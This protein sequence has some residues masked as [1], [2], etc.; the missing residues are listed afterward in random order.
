MSYFSNKQSWNTISGYNAFLSTYYEGDID[1]SGGDLVLRN[2]NVY[3][4]PS[5][6]INT[7]AFYTNIANEMH[8][9]KLP[10]CSVT[11]A[12]ASDLT[13]KS[14]VDSS[15]SSLLSSAISSLLSL[16]NTWTN[17][18][19]F[20]VL[21]SGPTSV[22]PSSPAD[23][24]TKQYADT[25]ISHTGQLTLV[26]TYLQPPSVTTTSALS[27]STSYLSDGSSLQGR[28]AGSILVNSFSTSHMSNAVQGLPFVVNVQCPISAKFIG[29]WEY[30]VVSNLTFTG[31]EVTFTKNGNSWLNYNGFNYIL[32]DNPNF[33]NFLHPI[34]SYCNATASTYL[35][36]GNFYESFENHQYLKNIGITFQTD[37]YDVSSDDVYNV[38]VSLQYTLL[39]TTNVQ[40][41]FE[42]NTNISTQS[43]TDGTKI[44][45]TLPDGVNYLPPKIIY[46]TMVNVSASQTGYFVNAYVDNVINDPKAC[47][48]RQYVDSVALGL[49]FTVLGSGGYHVSGVNGTP[50]LKSDGTALVV[51]NLTTTD[52]SNVLLNYVSYTSFTNTLSTYAKTADIISYSSLSGLI[53]S[54]EQVTTLITNLQI[55]VYNSFVL[56]SFFDVWEN[57]LKDVYL[58]A[59]YVTQANLSNYV[60]TGTIDVSTLTPYS[61]A[62][63][64][65]GHLCTLSNLIA[66]Q[67][68]SINDRFDFWKSNT[69]DDLMLNW[70][71]PYYVKNEV[72]QN[73]TLSSVLSSYALT[74]SLPDLTPYTLSVRLQN[75]T[76]SSVLSSYALTS[77]LPDLT[78]YALITTLSSLISGASIADTINT[79]TNFNHFTNSSEFSNSEH[80]NTNL[81]IL[82]GND[83]TIPI[84]P[85]NDGHIV[86]YDSFINDFR[87]S[88]SYAGDYNWG[89]D[90]YINNQNLGYNYYS[91]VFI[92]LG[93]SYFSGIIK[94]LGDY[95]IKGKLKVRGD[96]EVQ[97]TTTISGYVKTSDLSPYALTSSLPAAPDLTPYV[98]NQVLQNY[99]LSS[100]LSSY[101]LTS[102]L[103]NLAPIYTQLTTLSS[104]IRGASIANTVNTFTN[105]NYFNDRVIFGND[106]TIP[107][108]NPDDSDDITI[109]EYTSF[110]TDLA[111]NRTVGDFRLTAGYSGTFYW[112][113][114][115]SWR[116]ANYKQSSLIVL[117]DSYF[118]GNSYQLG[119][120][121]R[122]GNT[123]LAGRFKIDGRILCNTIEQYL[124]NYNCSFGDAFTFRNQMQPIN[125]SSYLFNNEDQINGYGDGLDSTMNSTFQYRNTSFGLYNCRKLTTGNNNCCIANT[126]LANLTTGNGNVVCGNYSGNFIHSGSYNTI[127]GYCVSGIISDSS[128]STAI[129]ALSQITESH[130]IV[131]G[132]SNEYVL[133]QGN[134]YVQGTISGYVTT[135]DLT[136]YALTSSL[137]DLSPYAMNEVL[138]NYTLSSSLPDLTPYALSVGLQNYT[139]SSSLSSYALTSAL[140]DLTPYALSVRLQNYTLSSSLSSYAL[141]SALPDLT[142]YAL[143]VRLQNY[144]L[145]SVLSSYALT[146][147]LPDLTP[148]AL[149]VRLQ[150]YTLSSV[151]SSYALTSA[152]SSYVDIT[153]NQSIAG[154]KT[155]STGIVNSSSITGVGTIK[156]TNTTTSSSTATGALVV[157]GGA[158]IGGA[159]NVGSG[160]TI[161]S[162]QT[163]HA[164]KFGTASPTAANSPTGQFVSF[165]YT[166]S[167][168]P[169]VTTTLLYKNLIGVGCY[170][171]IYSVST[172]GFYIT[173]AVI[174]SN[175]L[176]E[177]RWNINWIAIN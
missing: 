125:G 94:H 158:G 10:I 81:C 96:L 117:G 119:D 155:F 106:I 165:G 84:A 25:L 65:S 12:N 103:P 75:Y 139:L 148:Y 79:F 156:T 53:H 115:Q 16:A 19:T 133:I 9:T 34:S 118:S 91:S 89:F 161:G 47:V 99:T 70:Y 32:N 23:L 87:L 45:L 26:Y 51:G 176:C 173:V 58:P 157:T 112:R 76:L 64:I 6:I 101:A 150:N 116:Y 82:V 126:S 73:Y 163:V 61:Y 85:D 56:Q 111:N 1:I 14:Y 11:P 152:L 40:T 90:P 62:Q 30:A 159:L 31:F 83:I 46:D 24:V 149:S 18:Q 13:N 166:F 169:V 78:P 54:N 95:I 4:S 86:A 114:Q 60:P 36:N 88:Q 174:G 146:S 128:Y 55:S 104:L 74:S 151:L 164:M 172:T 57:G 27:Y 41:Y 123:E 124:P 113:G 171:Y 160:I 39:Q 137:P 2:G 68:F 35:I 140:P 134:L 52:I 141:T 77:Q 131:L 80:P 135:S 129:G 71:L 59:I 109:T 15:T 162:S 97:G 21:P 127:L 120:L 72:L 33:G 143:S 154:T 147:S 22:F 63:S 38:Y 121:Y 145:S 42:I 102:S 17:K 69:F 132:T 110:L 43:T 98:M 49:N 93:D 170:T 130:Q 136:P 5:G 142:P 122:R 66:Q 107:V 20:N 144:T 100:T 105:K 50:L 29:Q 8:L 153:N 37:P 108:W 44:K 7:G 177:D 48:N 67:I 167:S 138:Q 175:Q 28:S 92:V 3:M 168:T